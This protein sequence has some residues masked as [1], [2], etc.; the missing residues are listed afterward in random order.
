MITKWK[1]F[2]FKS[3]RR[4]TD[5][6][7]SPITIFAGANSS[8]KSTFLQ[9]ILLIAQ[10]LSHKVSSRSVVLNGALA[11]LGQFDDLRSSDSDAEQIF[12]GW[13]CTPAQ[14]GQLDQTEEVN[15]SML[16]AI[17]SRRSGRFASLS[18]DL[19]F[20]ADPSGPQREILQLQPRP[21][22]VQVSATKR[23]DDLIDV[24]SKITVSRATEAE[25]TGNKLLKVEGE[26]ISEDIRNS[27][28]YDV[29]LDDEAL[30]EM[31]D[32]LASADVIGCHLRHFLPAR[33][34]LRIDRA[35]ESAQEI[36]T[37]LNSM[38][39]SVRRYRF[40]FLGSDHLILPRAVFAYLKES[41]LEKNSGDS[42]MSELANGLFPEEEEDVSALEWFMRISRLPS[43]HRFAL[44]KT[45]VDTDVLLNNLAN[46]F[47]NV[48]GESSSVVQ[49]RLPSILM[50]AVEY[51]DWF[52]SG[53]VKY[54]GPLRDEPKP[55]YPLVASADPSD[56][57]LRGEF[58]AAVLDLHKDRQVRYIT[59]A[60]F[61]SPAVKRDSVT[62]SLSAA[63]TDWLQYLGVAE[64]ITTRDRGKL[65]HELKVSVAKGGKAQ[66]LTHVGVGVSQVLPILVMSLLA[67]RDTTLVFEQPEL[68]LHPRVQT[69]LGDFFLSMAF[70]GKQCIVETHSEYLINRLRFRAASASLQRPL[71]D[72]MKM[73]FVEKEEGASAFREVM[74]NEYGAILD[75]P[76]GFFDQSQQEAEEILKSASA[77]RRAKR[78]FNDAER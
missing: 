27:L 51:F 10:T 37:A 78:E 55:L 65:G 30:D 73:Y 42:E 5:L 15:P 62:R 70:L 25:T 53:A 33:L 17:A 61:T 47:R 13:E 23:G 48:I 6:S 3:L 16:R 71:T 7:L 24:S 45:F 14:E 20:V 29:T 76:K 40:R 26:T 50:E 57:G 58:T 32:Y 41:F 12:I 68:H 19:A 8:G 56:V 75:W 64:S 31:R 1:V 63:V 39:S 36:I 34:T 69:L 74:V 21:F 28:Q 18:C 54:L 22:S 49:W 4:E 60:Q 77:K 72:I 35:E 43:K 46:I 44:R 2:N 11:R 9:T 67:E 59:S 52:F 38:P 66:D